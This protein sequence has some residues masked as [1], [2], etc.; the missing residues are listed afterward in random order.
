MSNR[1]P[2]C[3]NLDD[4]HTAGPAFYFL[5]PPTRFFHAD[6][7][8]SIIKEGYIND[9][10]HIDWLVFCVIISLVCIEYINTYL[11]WHA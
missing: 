10:I 6:S 9:L 2:L 11:D 1:L 3:L 8:T 7:S 5:A 4:D